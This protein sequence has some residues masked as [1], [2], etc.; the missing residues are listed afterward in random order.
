MIECV[1]DP[2]TH[3]AVEAVEA[4]WRLE[5][6]RLIAG[7]VRMV[8]DVG[9]AEDL[10]HDALV[11]ALAQWPQTGVPDNPGAWLMTTAKRRGVDQFRRRERGDQIYAAIAHAQ[12]SDVSEEDFL[13]AVDHVEDDVLR[14]MFV[15]C[16]PVLTAGGA[17]HADTQAGW[18]VDHSG[19][20]ASVSDD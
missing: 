6:T 11:A 13:A 14:L 18:W 20:R 2:T 16:H 17:V 10:A 3:E 4:V 8:R 7:L 5:S 12:G 19:D 9:L 15:C 1:T